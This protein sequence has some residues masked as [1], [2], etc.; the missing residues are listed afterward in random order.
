MSSNPH[1]YS[2]KVTD[3]QRGITR[4]FSSINETGAW[5]FKQVATYTEASP[6]VV[7]QGDTED[8]LIPLN[9]SGYEENHLLDLYYDYDLNNFLP[10]NVGDIYLMSIRGKIIPSNQAGHLDVIITSDG[11]QFNPI[12]GSTITFNKSA[13]EEH[14]LSGKYLI[15]ITEPLV[16][17]GVRV[18][19]KA[20]NTD[21]DLYDYS[22]T[23]VKLFSDRGDNIL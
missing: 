4:S 19:V 23:I 9:D 20:N 15:F 11:A 14:L 10:P 6:L 16:T 8:L 2:T 3:E 5:L 18:S 12:E 7:S 1:L 13:G 21:C 17:S 22:F